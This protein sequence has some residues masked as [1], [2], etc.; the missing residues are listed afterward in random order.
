MSAD[1]RQAELGTHVIEAKLPAGVVIKLRFCE[2]SIIHQEVVP[3]SWQIEGS[4]PLA[5]NL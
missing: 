1:F 2:S 4:I 5:A 3:N